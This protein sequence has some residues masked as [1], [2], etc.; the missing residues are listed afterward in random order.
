[1]DGWSVGP[2]VSVCHVCG[3]R[4]RVSVEEVVCVARCVA[5]NNSK[6]HMFKC[7]GAV[8]FGHT[9]KEEQEL[10]QICRVRRQCEVVSRGF[11]FDIAVRFVAHCCCVLSLPPIKGGL[12]RYGARCD[13]RHVQ[14]SQ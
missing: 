5:F 4:A 9:L 8:P 12:Q 3:V 7:F 2:V 13:G 10:S 1:M 11:D 14:V 6:L